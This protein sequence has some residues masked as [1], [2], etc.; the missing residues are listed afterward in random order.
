[1]ETDATPGLQTTLQVGSILAERYEILKLLGEGGMGAVYK[2]RDRELDRVVALKVIRPELA[3]HPSILARFKQELILA[4]KITHRSVIRIF[5]L[6]VA[7]GIR[8][9]TMEFVE[10]HDLSTLLDEQ[11]KYSTKEASK[12]LLQVGSALEAAHAEGVVHRDLKPQ[13]IMVEDNGRACVMD[14]GLARSVE[15]TGMTQVGAVLGTPAYMSPEQ[16]K[17]LTADE[18]SD[19]FSLGVIA[20]RMLTG[21]LPY[22]G[23]TA[24]ASM[25]M[26]T[27]GPPEKQPKDIDPDLPQVLNDIVLKLLAT[28]PE[29]R[30]QTATEFVQD[31][32]EWSDGT[33][34][35]TIVLPTQVNTSMMMTPPPPPPKNNLVKWAGI[36]AAVVLAAGLGYFGYSRINSA[37]AEPSAPVTVLIADFNNHTG[38]PV[39]SGTLESTLKLA[40]EG[41]SFISAYDR[42]KL[43]DLGAQAI[44]GPLDESAAQT[45]AVNQGVNVVIAGALDQQG[46]GYQL[47]LRAIQAVTG[48]VLANLDEKA[49]NKE[50]VLFALTKL[51][52][53]VRSELGDAT[54]ESAQRFAMETLSAASLEAVHEYSVALD[55]LSSGKN[56]DAQSHFSKAVDL[57]QKFG[58]AYAGMASAQ[59]NV[60]QQQEA[61]KSIKLA[62]SHIDNMTER[63]RYRT[64]ALLYMLVGNPEKCVDEYGSLLAKYAADTGAHNNLGICLTQL[65]K[66]PE[67]LSHVKQAVTIL[68]KR[69]TYRVNVALY[70]SYAG[71]F[72]TGAKEAAASLQLNPSYAT[73]FLASA[74]AALGQDQFPQ[75]TEFYTK[76]QGVRPS[77]G[78]MGLAD[79][80]AYEGRY[81][82]AITMLEKGAADDLA[83][84]RP[85]GAADKYLL[86][87]YAQLSRGQK[88]AAAEAAKKALGA[89]KSTKARFLAG[90]L[91]VENQDYAKA[92]ELEMSLSAELQSEPQASGK[93]LA[94]EIALAK[95]DARQAIKLIT[96]ANTLLDTWIGR[97]DLGRAYLAASAFI[98]ADSEFDRCIKRRGEALALFLDEVPSFSFLPPVYYYQGRVREGLKSSNYVESYRKYIAI[99]GKSGED[100]LLAD[101]RKR[102]GQ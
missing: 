43:R 97:F 51:A 26:R 18:R 41:A 76:L 17:G 11:G 36:A 8:F 82:D 93:L 88:A 77:D 102:S 96:E 67:A 84:K 6:G 71:D 28:N 9:I 21:V 89:S 44:N 47:S 34:T 55:A 1:V 101:A 68:P 74:F 57:D 61:E 90:R 81:Q 54:T 16:A 99:R 80:A 39:F 78:L 22:K 92:T 94:G 72:A 75:A 56:E 58:L 33:F 62:I 65:R 35:R 37:P 85:D 24:L 29:E 48:K 73:G 53:K 95:G 3:G 27:Q 50:Q 42:T 91:L 100:T 4:R 30:Y 64:R 7:Q 59:R 13:N 5:D 46:T 70:S 23:D 40:L 86:A 12:L 83:A 38:D 66:L 10:G 52:G 25:L 19:L 49:S 60:G 2:A 45:V 87:G 69:A 32:R 98:E 63:E 15:N 14:F 20:Y 79:M 31:L